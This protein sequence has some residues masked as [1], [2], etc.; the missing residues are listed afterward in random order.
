VDGI[1]LHAEFAIANIGIPL[2][3]IKQKQGKFI[4]KLPE[5]GNFLQALTPD[6]LFT[7][8]QISK[9]MNTVRLP[10]AKTGN[11]RSKTLFLDFE[12]PFAIA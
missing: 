3:S 8:Q 2:G 9:P 10:G 11:L 4:N 7:E 5:T 12:V 6:Q 1:G